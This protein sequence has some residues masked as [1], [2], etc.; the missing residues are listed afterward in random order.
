M[1]YSDWSSR[2]EGEDETMSEMRR[3]R[4]SEYSGRA[5]VRLGCGPAYPSLSAQPFLKYSECLV[6]A[7]MDLLK[8]RDQ[9]SRAELRLLYGS[10]DWE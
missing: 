1:I 2:E 8:E 7:H 4:E 3:T 10:A 9:K 6:E 5:P